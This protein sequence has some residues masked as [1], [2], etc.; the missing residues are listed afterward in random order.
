MD[1]NF[2]IDINPFKKGNILKLNISRI[3]EFKL[4]FNLVMTYI[5]K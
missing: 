5:T 2:G 4:F 3:K 1:K